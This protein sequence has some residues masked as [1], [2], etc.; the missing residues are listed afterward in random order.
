M[1]IQLTKTESIKINI[2]DLA[3][4]IWKFAHITMGERDW[5]EWTDEDGNSAI[6]CRL[7]AY[8]SSWELK[9]GL[10]DFDTDHRGFWSYSSIPYRCTREQSREIARE[11]IEGLEQAGTWGVY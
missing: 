11:L 7:R 4:N 1:K 3:D 6:D 10:S 2:T 5:Q 9:V 8:D